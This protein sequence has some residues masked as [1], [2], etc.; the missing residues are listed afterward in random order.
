MTPQAFLKALMARDGLNSNSL[1]RKTNGKTTQ[2]QIHRFLNSQ[3][4]EPKR[5]TLRPVADFFKVPVDAFFDEAVA[6]EVWRT[7]F[8]EATTVALAQPPTPPTH[9]P[10]I[11]LAD[12]LPVVLGRLAAGLG[13]YR[14]G[15]VLQALQSATRPGAPLEDIER[16]LLQWLSEPPGSA[17]PPAKR[18]I[19]G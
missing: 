12:A 1:S 4:K 19:A 17:A 9:P 6:S 15:Q 13:D 8:S 16:D 10:Q 11:S 2:P 14:A 3:V 18:Q 5:S 7:K